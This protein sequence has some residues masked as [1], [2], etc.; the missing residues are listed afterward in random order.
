MSFVSDSDWC[1]WGRTDPYF[2]VVSFDEFKADRIADN[3]DRFFETGRREIDLV[4]KD[5]KSRYGDAAR[6]RALDFGSGV[7]RLVLPL[8]AHY[9][10]VVGVDI[11]EAMN[12]EARQNCRKSGIA[13]A[14]FVISDDELS[15]VSG[16]FDLVHSYIV[17]QHIPVERGLALTSAL[18][19]RL[20]P[21]GVA[22]LHY[23]LQRT[24]PPARA[25]V[26]LLKHKIPFGRVLMNLAQ[27]RAWDAPAMQMNNYPLVRILRLFE[28]HGL[29][30]VF[31][32]PEWQETA[33]TARI[34]GR[35]AQD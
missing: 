2:G 31:I 4:L 25:L 22:S 5:I 21:G 27:G 19:S 10:K 32:A 13:N 17:L 14:E 29:D 20:A 8:T 23:S 3:R 34:Y 30:G 28:E 16:D 35:K 7:G 6:R 24:L 1:K 18:L 26:Y 9:D 11:S 12:A 15:G 33:L